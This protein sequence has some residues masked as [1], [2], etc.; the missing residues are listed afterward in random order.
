MLQIANYVEAGFLYG[1]V[2]NKNKLCGKPLT[3]TLR[4]G[5]LFE[6]GGVRGGI[7]SAEISAIGRCDANVCG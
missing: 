6:L 3:L 7:H 1:I 2:R 4:L 5:V